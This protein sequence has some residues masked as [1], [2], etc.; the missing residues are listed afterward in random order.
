M[1]KNIVLSSPDTEMGPNCEMSEADVSSAW[2]DSR[3]TFDL[4]ANIFEHIQSPSTQPGHNQ[5]SDDQTKKTK[6]NNSMLTISVTLWLLYCKVCL[7]FTIS[8]DKA[9]ISRV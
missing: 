3:N 1:H 4:Q 9:A 2:I 6:E 7:L 5:P 8:Y